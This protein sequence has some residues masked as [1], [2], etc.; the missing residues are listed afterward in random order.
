MPIYEYR[1]ESC[2]GLEEVMQKMA[3]AAPD[4]CS[5]CG[6]GPMEK[7]MSRST[8]FALRGTGWYVTDF[9]GGNSP[10][11]D[12]APKAAESAPP[13]APAPAKTTT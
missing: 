1:C 9:K 5:S 4:K 12:A 10:K 11:T 13:A 3:D 6:K 2:G 7:Q 8:S